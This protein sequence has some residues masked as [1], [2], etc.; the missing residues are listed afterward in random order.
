MSYAKGEGVSQDYV[1]AYMWFNLAATRFP[2]SEV[3]NRELAVRNRGL[4]ASK[5]TGEQIVEAQN[6]AREWKPR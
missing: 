2:A 1:S 3:R 5:M 4:V 6:C